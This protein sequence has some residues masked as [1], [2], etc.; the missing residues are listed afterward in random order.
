MK[1]SQLLP[2]NIVKASEGND[3]VDVDLR[4]QDVRKPLVD[5]NTS[6]LL[7]IEKF[8]CLIF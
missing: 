3:L 1:Q 8:S 6:F 2:E 5:Y 4:M 7:L